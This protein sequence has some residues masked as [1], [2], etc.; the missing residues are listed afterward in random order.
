MVWV[1]GEECSGE[2]FVGLVLGSPRGFRVLSNFRSLMPHYL[3]Y[4][5]LCCIILRFLPA[6]NVENVEPKFAMMGSALGAFSVPAPWVGDG[7][8]QEDKIE[9]G[10]RMH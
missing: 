6:L 2:E 10:R 9:R 3:S 5:P 7:G 4:L 1:L 8:L